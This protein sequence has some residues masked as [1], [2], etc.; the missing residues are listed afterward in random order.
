MV[1][2][3]IFFVAKIEPIEWKR[4]SLKLPATKNK[5]STLCTFKL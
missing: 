2:L 4:Q 1:F 5:Q 3:S